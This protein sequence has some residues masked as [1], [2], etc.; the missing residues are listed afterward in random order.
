LEKELIGTIQKEFSYTID[1]LGI[2][3]VVVWDELFVISFD[4]KWILC[5]CKLSTQVEHGK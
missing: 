1:E 4:L 5:N 2:N 3:D